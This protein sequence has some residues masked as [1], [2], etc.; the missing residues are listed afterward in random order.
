MA[1]F[2]ILLPYNYSPNDQKSI[3]FTIDTFAGHKDVH[4]TLFHAYPPLPDIDLA[5]SPENR[6]M[7]SGMTY[8]SAELKEREAALGA[9]AETLAAGG[10]DADAISCVFKKRVR[11]AA[12]EIVEQVAGCNVLVLSRGGGKVTH[13]FTRSIYARVVGALRGVTIC[14]AT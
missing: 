3:R 14:V 10:F 12:E 7:R 1:T 6:K 5:A 8:L 11:S 9:V 13:F 4:I 2:R